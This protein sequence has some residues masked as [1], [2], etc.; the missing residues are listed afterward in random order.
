L[1]SKFAAKPELFNPTVCCGIAAK[2]FIW[3]AAK[4]V[5]ILLP[6]KLRGKIK[7]EVWQFTISFITLKGFCDVGCS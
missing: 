6:V 2:Q 7:Q 4:P 3:P 1:V 5:N